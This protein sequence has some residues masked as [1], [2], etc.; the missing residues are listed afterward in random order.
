MLQFFLRRLI[1]AVATVFGVMLLTFLLSQVSIGDAAATYVNPRAG[2]KARQA[3]LYR[4]GF[5][6]PSV[7]NYDRRLYIEDRVGGRAP[8]TVRDAAGSNASAALAMVLPGRESEGAAAER[9]LGRYVF[10]LKPDTP[11]SKLTAGK[12]LQGTAAP[13]ASEAENEESPEAATQPASRPQPN[14]VM[15][16]ELSDGSD[17]PVDLD[18]AATAGQLIDRINNAPF[19]NGRVVAGIT[20]WQPRDFFDSQFFH[21]LIDS[22]QFKSKSF[23]TDQ[24]LQAI[25]A[26][27]AGF[28]LAITVPSMAAGWVLGMALSCLVAY[29]RDKWVDRVGVLLSV[30]GMCIP[31]LAYMIL[32]QWLMFQ[33]APEAA[34]GLRHPTNIYVPVAIMVI[35]G[36]GGH[37]RFYRTILLDQVGQD[38]VRTARAKGVSTPAILLKHVLKNCMLPILTDLV[39]AIPFLIMGSILLEQFFGIPGLGDLMIASISARDV[40]IVT[41]LVFLTSVVYVLS[42]LLTDLLYAVFDP[43]IRLS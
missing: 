26:R 7:F 18:N 3:W 33:I 5:N 23:Q 31:F 21:H 13:P 9:M 39:T 2:E 24:T 37:V 30:L 42:L 19:N 22:V 43:R 4:H 14:A 41:S 35:A 40:P 36:L 11:I 16:F 15:V 38:Y 6:K 25:I 34:W 8:L 27:H 10:N 28:S 29:Y 32:G 20:Q 17:L 12:P 1:Q